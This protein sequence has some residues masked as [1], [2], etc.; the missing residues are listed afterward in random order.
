MLNCAAKNTLPKSDPQFTISVELS[1]RRSLRFCTLFN[2]L[3]IEANLNFWLTLFGFQSII[4]AL[5]AISCTM[6]EFRSNLRFLSFPCRQFK[7]GCCTGKGSPRINWYILV[8]LLCSF[9][10]FGSYMFA[11]M[12]VDIARN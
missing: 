1:L 10:I 7:F 2:R 9:T 8:Y 3:L 11:S 6:L 12:Q 4:L 5:Q